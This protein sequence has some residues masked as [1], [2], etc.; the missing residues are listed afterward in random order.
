MCFWGWGLSL[1]P[2]INKPMDEAD[3]PEAHEAS[4]KALELADA[5]RASPV[6]KALI[7]ALATRYPASGLADRSERD[8]AF[9]DAMRDVATRFPEDLDASTLFAESVMDLTPWDY[10]EESGEAKPT[11]REV[12]AVLESV[13]QRNE[14]HPG[15][16]HYYIHA[17]EASNTPERA[18][19][20]ADR[21]ISLVPAAGHLVHMPAHIYLRV[22]RYDD[23]VVANEKASAA[24]ESYIDQCNAQGFYPAMYYPHNIHFLWFSATLEGRSRMAHDASRRLVRNVPEEMIAKFPGLQAFKPIPI[25]SLVR[26]GAWDEIL[27]EEAPPAGEVYTSAMWQYAQGLA[28][29][30]SGRNDEAMAR[31]KSLSKLAKSKGIKALDKE[32]PAR[33]LSKIAMLILKGEMAGAGGDHDKRVKALAEA[34]RVQDTLPYT[35][36]PHWYYPVRQ[37]LGAALLAA[38][39]PAE[40]E[41]VYRT[42]LEK[43]PRN[44]WSLFGLARSLEAQGK[45]AEADEAEAG[46]K[47]AWVRADFELSASAL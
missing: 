25:F 8:N 21:L 44:G 5:G 35:E 14:N 29:L 45:A 1:G 39:R 6:E 4:R 41:A 47:T 46:F 10:H 42:D 9:A 17:V 12:V 11:T 24:D 20:G 23:A 27:K 2:N 40:A 13:L 26:F 36:P 33:R 30:K 7:E 19:P 28:S 22:G 38:G 15:A 32:F 37:S 43:T 3:V 18:E 16:I 31:F 34:V